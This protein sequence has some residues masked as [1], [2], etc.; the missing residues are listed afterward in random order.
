MSKS[1]STLMNVVDRERYDVSLMLVSPTGAFMELLP[2][3]L[4]IITNPVWPALTS[5]LSGFKT[6][7]RI[8]HPLLA[9]LHLVRLAISP[10]NKAA[11][12]R[13]IAKLMP[14]LE[15]E[16]DMIVDFNGQQ[17]LYYMVDKLK[18]K[19]KVTF[20]HSDYK[21]WP[22]YYSADKKYFPK[23]DRVFTISEICADSLREMFPEAANKV[24]VMENIS[25]LQF[26]EKLA[27]QGDISD[28]MPAHSNSI[29]T[30]G[31]LCD[32]K[33]T[34]WALQAAKILKN[35]GVKFHWYFIGKNLDEAKYEKMKLDI[36]DCITFLGI[37]VNPYP[38]IK[39][40]T[41]IV[42]PSQFEGKSIALD[43]VKLLCKP[44][45]VTNF[46][47]VNDQFTDRYNASICDMTPESISKNIIE[48]LA[49]S[50]RRNLYISNLEKDKRDNSVEINKLYAI[51]D[52]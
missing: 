4:N 19:K 2:D 51:V 8:N 39:Q 18:A 5:R 10:I 28:E 9:T 47:T 44:T 48:L 27:V 37:K 12:A 20:F 15:D 25:S 43:E 32:N 17:Q 46:S 50:S 23:V 38:Y 49:D 7:C 16:Y 35:R 34:H 14:P 30:I 29:L 24:S 40:A 36:D 21:K 52:D 1:M 3:D 22:Y 41:I 45:V 13:L 33:G 6:L 26:I 31:H 11:G 42:H